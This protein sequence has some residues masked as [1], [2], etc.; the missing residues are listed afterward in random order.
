MSMRSATPDPISALPQPCRRSV[1]IVS[2]LATI[3]LTVALVE[4]DGPLRTASARYGILSFEFSGSSESAAA[5]LQS[6]N[7]QAQVCAGLSL[8]LDYAYLLA[9][10]TALASCCAWASRRRGGPWRALGRRL[11]YGQ[12]MAALFDAVENVGLIALLLGSQLAFW[13]PMAAGCAALKFALIIAGLFY[14]GVGVF[15]TE[16]RRAADQGSCQRQ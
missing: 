3:G 9:Y 4:L 16:D 10:S 1:A 11:V 8:G 5:I 13:P 2:L 14:T 6:W 7:A 12:W 15:L